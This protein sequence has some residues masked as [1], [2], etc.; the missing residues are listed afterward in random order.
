MKTSQLNRGGGGTDPST[1]NAAVAVET[2]TTARLQEEGI[3]DITVLNELHDHPI[4]QVEAVIRYVAHCRTRDDP[5]RPGLIV[6]LLR[7][8]FGL[9]HR[10]RQPAAS[11]APPRTRGHVSSDLP[12]A[13]GLPAPPAD[14]TPRDPLLPGAA[15]TPADDGLDPVWQQALTVLQA[16]LAAESFTTWIQP[17]RLLLLEGETAVLG[18]P[19]V[20]VRDEIEAHYRPLVEA[21]VGQVLG[22]PITVETV[23]GASLTLS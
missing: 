19:N 5:R 20:F 1:S 12:V 23:I 16:Q 15:V 22:R 3:V 4:A 8:G 14:D 2:A 9:R 17:N 11:C 13:S 7:R 10:S 18:T 21:A 6:H